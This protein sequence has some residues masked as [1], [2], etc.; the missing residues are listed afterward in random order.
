MIRFNM[1][2]LLLQPLKESQHRSWHVV[3]VMNRYIVYASHRRGVL[4]IKAFDPSCGGSSV[5]INIVIDSYRDDELYP[6]LLMFANRI[7]AIKQK[8]IEAADATAIEFLQQLVTRSTMRVRIDVD[9]GIVDTEFT[10]EDGFWFVH[11]HLDD[12]ILIKGEFAFYLNSEMKSYNVITS[13]IDFI[14]GN[15]L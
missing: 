7:D 13:M 8:S 12:A 2:S 3:C 6:L 15:K 1:E 5:V 11:R 9:D 4:K 10:F 14:K